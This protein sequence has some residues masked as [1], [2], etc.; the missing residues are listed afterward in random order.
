[1]K[2][3]YFFV[4]IFLCNIHNAVAKDIDVIISLPPG[5]TTDIVAKILGDEYF[6]LTGDKFIINYAVGGGSATV[7]AVKFKNSHDNTVILGTTSMNIFAPM[8]EK[9]LPY[10]DKDFNYICFIGST[11]GI[12]IANPETNIKNIKDMSD[13]LIEIKRPFIGGYNFLYNMNIDILKKTGHLDKKIEIVPHKGAPDILL[14]VLNGNLPVG[15]VGTT[16]NLFQLAQEGK[17][18]ILGSTHDKDI[19]KDGITVP[20]VS[21][22]LSVPQA[23]GGFIL[24]LKPSVKK[25]FYDEFTTNVKTITQSE[26]FKSELLKVNV[27][28]YDIFGSKETYDMILRIRKSIEPNL[29]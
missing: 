25:E 5:S 12:W 4:L 10:S 9:D 2:K 19:V 22:T 28:Q 27:F 24:S 7:A 13:R 29:K 11:P 16:S 23:T 14:N 21:Q 26:R 15:L 20:S 17:I 1:M 18:N 8:L 3:I 6:K